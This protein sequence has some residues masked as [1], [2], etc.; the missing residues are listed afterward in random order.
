MQNPWILPQS[1]KNVAGWKGQKHPIFQGPP[2]M[3]ISKKADVQ[4]QKFQKCATS[5]GRNLKNILAKSQKIQFWEKNFDFQKKI[6]NFTSKK[7]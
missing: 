4:G 2:G 6:S 3:E 1:F 5:R 7:R